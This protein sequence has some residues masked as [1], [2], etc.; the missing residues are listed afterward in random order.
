MDQTKENRRLAAAY[1][2]DERRNEW[3]RCVR[4]IRAEP[5]PYVL[6][7]ATALVGLG[8]FLKALAG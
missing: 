4:A 1:R 3:Y 7:A 6:L 8:M 2:R 5:W